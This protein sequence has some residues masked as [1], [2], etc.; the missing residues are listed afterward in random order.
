MKI[1]IKHLYEEPLFVIKFWGDIELWIITPKE[2]REIRMIYP[3]RLHL[4]RYLRL[5]NYKDK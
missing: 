3:T 1:K 2:T 5:L 4:E